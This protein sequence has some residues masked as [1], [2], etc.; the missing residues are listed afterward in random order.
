MN[1]KHCGTFTP[2]VTVTQRYCP[3]CA[4]E[5]LRQIAADERRRTPRFPVRDMTTL[6]LS[7]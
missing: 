1:C 3:P 5:V 2:R 4:N 6:V 7:R